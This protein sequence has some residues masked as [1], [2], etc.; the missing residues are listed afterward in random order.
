MNTKSP[1]FKYSYHLS[2]FPFEFS[3]ENRCAHNSRS[4][5]ITTDLIREAH[6]AQ[7]NEL[8][9]LDVTNIVINLVSSLLSSRSRMGGN[10]INI[11]F[12]ITTDLIVDAHKAYQNEHK[13]VDI[14]RKP[15]A[16]ASNNVRFSRHSIS[17][18]CF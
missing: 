17:L 3:L 10:I 15:A 7:R 11:L 1:Y 2:L 6:K 13:S 5:I 12:I 4:L 8:E 16:S 14:S 18:L 9:G